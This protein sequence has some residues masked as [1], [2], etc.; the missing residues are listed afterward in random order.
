MDNMTGNVAYSIS[1][2][3]AGSLFEIKKETGKL[4]AISELDREF[5]SY[6]KLVVSYCKYGGE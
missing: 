1:G 6:Y 4:Y 3:G 5:K 2:L